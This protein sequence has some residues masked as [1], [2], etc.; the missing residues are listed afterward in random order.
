MADQLDPVGV[1][2]NFRSLAATVETNVH[3]DIPLNRLP[4]LVRL[5]SS[6]DQGRTLTVTFGLDYVFARR[7]QDRYPTPNLH[8]I[9]QTARNAILSPGLLER[10]GTAKTTRASC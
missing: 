10:R 2:R 6:V 1:L 8:R 7:K 3:T 4:S 5:V 9:R